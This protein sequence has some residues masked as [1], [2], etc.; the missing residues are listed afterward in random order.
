MGKLKEK[1]FDIFKD[2]KK[3]I[4]YIITFIVL[5]CTLMTGIITRKYDL[6]VGDIPK[7]DIKAHREI[8]DESA[9]EAR[10]KEAEEKVDKQY[11]LRT[12]VQKQSEEKIKGFF[13]SVEKVLA[14]DKSEEEKAKLI[15]RAPFKITDEQANKIASMNAQSTK[16]LESVCID[17]LNKAYE[18]PIEDGNEQDLKDA[19]KEYTDFISSSDLS[20]SEKAIAL[21]FVNVV[22]PNFFYDKEKTDELIKETLKQVPPVMIKKNQIVVSEGEPVTAH[23]LE[24]LGTLGLLSDSASGIYI[25]IALGILV[26]IVMYLQYGYIHKYYPAINKEF[27]KIV[28]ISILNVF[29]VIL[30]RLFGMMSNYIIPLACM[31]MLITLLLN[32]KISLV[33]SMLNVILIGGAVGFNPNIIILAILN[34]VLGGTLLRKM[35]QRNDILYS[36]ITVAVLS[37]I[38][39][40][41]VGTLTTNNFME[42]LAD[43]TFAAAGAILS[44]IL[45]IGVLPFFES[46]FDIVTNAK[47]L[48][49]SNPNNPL[50]KKLLME[51]PGTYHHSILVANLAELAAEQVGGNPLL[52]RIGAYYHD[53]GKTKRPYFFRENQFGKKNPHDRLKPEVSSKIII[54][55][56]KD[57]SELAKEYNLPKTI[58]DFIVTHHGE[59]LVKY[60]YLTVKNNSENPDEVK[61]EDFKYPGPKP[62]SKEQGIVMLAD[63][64]E[65]AVRSINEPT[66]EKIEKMVNNIIDDKLA[67]GQLDNCDLTL[68]DI[69]KIKKCFLKALNGIHHERIEYP[70]DN[71]KEKK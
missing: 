25:Y 54:S 21:N 60:F 1:T 27:S 57:G 48:E 59:T 7:S 69:S 47:L 44:G 62:M 8:I 70:D 29:P 23:Q 71:K 30:A 45:T 49:L 15:P 24:L 17:G 36:S 61:E 11:S 3:I 28:M 18:A 13:S 33:F 56:V 68:R 50:L 37:S 34:V 43:S 16:N 41:S 67:S 19:K 40:F 2:Y 38:L 64:T 39:T 14:Q 35:Q 31:P 6:K 32:Y 12:D 46:T 63:S 22:E 26:I 66:E 53:V 51:A 52:A 4:L 58:H 42:I 5:Y 55:H 10:K 9:T 65:A 20:D